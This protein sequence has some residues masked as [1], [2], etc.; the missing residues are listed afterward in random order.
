MVRPHP[1]QSTERQARRCHRADH[2][3]PAREPA[4]RRD[5]R[6][7]LAGHVLAQEPWEVVRLPAIA[8]DDDRHRVE[9]VFGRQ[10]FD[11]STGEA[12]HPDREPTDML[13]QIRRVLGFSP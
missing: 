3:P 2:A 7:D 8:E 1:L 10:C 6:D 13:D 12:L 5:P 9:T 11:R 4:L